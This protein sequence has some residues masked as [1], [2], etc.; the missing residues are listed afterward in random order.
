MSQMKYPSRTK[1][2]FCDG[3]LFLGEIRYK[4][5]L[6]SREKGP[7]NEGRAK[8]WEPEERGE[9]EKLGWGVA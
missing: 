9:D 1:Y 4:L 8:G 5:W 2:F 3:G 7:G 6:M